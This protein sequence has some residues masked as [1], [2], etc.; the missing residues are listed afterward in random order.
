M[1]SRTTS[2]DPLVDALAIRLRRMDLVGWRRISTWAEETGL[3]LEDLR[4]LLAFAVKMDD[5][6]AAVS[7]L[8]ELAGLSPHVA[9]P[10]THSLRRRG[11]LHEEGR[12]YSLSQQGLELV[13]SFDA[14][15][16]E[17]IQAYVDTLDRDELQQLTEAFTKLRNTGGSG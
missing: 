6:P 2:T 3:S 10:A 5:D 11:Y 8:A 1:N 13:A 9:Y 15:R 7:E 14:A 4:L 12:H 16:R 17:G